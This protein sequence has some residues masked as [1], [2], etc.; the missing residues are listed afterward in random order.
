MPKRSWDGFV[1]LLK[2]TSKHLNFYI[3][4]QTELSRGK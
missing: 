4:T 3:L 2:Y 1:K